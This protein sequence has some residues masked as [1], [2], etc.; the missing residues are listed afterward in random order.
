MRNNIWCGQ[1]AG[2]ELWH[3]QPS[4]IDWD[5]D[6]LFVSDANAPLVVQAYR[7]KF[8]KLADV[9]S[10]LKWLPHGISADPQFIDSGRGDYRLRDSSPCINAG[11]P[12]GGINRLSTLG[13]APDL[14]AYEKR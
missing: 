1:Q 14:G 10:R 7:T 3:E 6:D 11:V 2:F 5:Y 4:P 13:T 9:R 8:P 12:L